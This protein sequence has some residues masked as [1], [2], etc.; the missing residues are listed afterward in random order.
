MTKKISLRIRR[1]YF[2]AIVAGAKIV[3][4]RKCT[5][6]WQKRLMTPPYPE[7][8]VFVCGKGVHRRKITRVTVEKTD[9]VL[10][11]RLSEQGKKDVPTESCYAIWLGDEINREAPEKL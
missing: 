1:I 10:N 4:L 8:A 6:F 7:E 2:D 5:E 3:E 9:T 11:R